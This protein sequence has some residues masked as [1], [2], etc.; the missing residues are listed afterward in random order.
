MGGGLV[1][2]ARIITTIGTVVAAIIV[3]GIV[4]KVLDANASNDIVNVV[5]DAA[6]WLTA[7][8]H[9]LFSLDDSDAQ[10]ALNW[11]LAAVVYCHRRAGDRPA[12]A[13]LT[14]SSAGPGRW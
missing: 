6:S 11:G 10:T 3:T 1:T 2:L 14:V 9:G 13:A 7:P 4:L 5:L 8:F 12:V